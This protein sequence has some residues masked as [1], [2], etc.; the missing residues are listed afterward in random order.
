MTKQINIAIS[1]DTYDKLN[2]K[3]AEYGTKLKKKKPVPVTTFCK[4]KLVEIAES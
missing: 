2:A 4:L 3:A 1:E